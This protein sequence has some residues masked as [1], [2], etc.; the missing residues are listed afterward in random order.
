MINFLMIERTQC[1]Y[2]RIWADVNGIEYAPE[3]FIGFNKATAVKR[4][5]KNHNMEGLKFE[6]MNLS[7]KK[8]D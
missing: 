4:Y 6:I 3:L 5:K 1:G 2:Y 7:F 8:E